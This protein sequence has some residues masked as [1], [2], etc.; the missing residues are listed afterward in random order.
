MNF[1]LEQVKPALRIFYCLLSIDCSRILV[2]FRFC[3]YSGLFRVIANTYRLYI[4]T[5]YSM[6]M[7]SFFIWIYLEP[8]T[9]SQN[10]SQIYSPSHSNSFKASGKIFLSRPNTVAIGVFLDATRFSQVETQ[11]RFTAHNIRTQRI[12]IS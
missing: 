7:H 8:A 1:S 3:G 4:H 9:D 6:F 2:M 10:L 11:L 12:A 5:V